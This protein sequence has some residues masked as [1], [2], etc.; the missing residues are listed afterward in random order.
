MKKRIKNRFPKITRVVLKI[1]GKIFIY[2]VPDLKF[3]GDGNY[4]CDGLYYPP[5]LK[6]NNCHLIY[7]DSAID[8]K[9]KHFQETLIHELVHVWQWEHDLYSVS[10]DWHTEKLK[11]KKWARY[12]KKHYD[13]AI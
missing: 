4:R 13:I 8:I 7:I 11:F 5:G 6:R 1:K 12:L 2:F 9:S 10:G 3:D